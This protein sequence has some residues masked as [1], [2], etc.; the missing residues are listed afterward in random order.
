M[1][2]SIKIQGK[3]EKSG[4][5]IHDGVPSGLLMNHSYGLL[6]LFELNGINLNG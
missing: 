5:A 4:E 2:C 6:D 1:S 3:H